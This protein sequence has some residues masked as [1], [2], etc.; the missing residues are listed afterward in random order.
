MLMRKIGGLWSP[1]D[2]DSKAMSREFKPNRVYEFRLVK[3]S[4]RSIPHHQ[5][6]FSGLLELAL[7]YWNPV[8]GC[9]S[10]NEEAILESFTRYLARSANI[11]QDA[12]ETVQSAF[13]DGVKRKRADKYDVPADRQANKEAL[14]KWVKE[15]IGFF[16]LYLTPDG[17]K[18]ELKSINFQ[19]MPTEEEFQDFYR[20]AFSAIWSLVLSHHFPSEAEAQ[21]A[22]DQLQAMG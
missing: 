12:L 6:Y 8:S 3:Q 18:K 7:D 21:D 11:N 14:H 17:W 15:E 5:M 13:L 10:P 4:T 19:S 20:P 9:V 1:L 22:V 2:A 16:D